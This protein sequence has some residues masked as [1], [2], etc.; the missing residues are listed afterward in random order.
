MNDQLAFKTMVFVVLH[1][2]EIAKRKLDD[3]SSHSLFADLKK[4]LN[5]RESIDEC[6]KQ[7]NDLFI[8]ETL[9]G[10]CDRIL[11]DIITR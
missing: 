8:E 4:K 5:I 7:L 10:Q 2:G 3:I 11:Q 9:D 1:D 6:F